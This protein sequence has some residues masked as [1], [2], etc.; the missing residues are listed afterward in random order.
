MKTKELNIRGAMLYAQDKENSD[1]LPLRNWFQLYDELLY[2]HQSIASAIKKIGLH[3]VT[4]IT[5]KVSEKN[6]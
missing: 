3:R 6:D 5:I 1:V 2:E 4:S